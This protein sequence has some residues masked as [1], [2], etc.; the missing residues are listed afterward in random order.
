MSG[1]LSGR[2][3][4]EEEVVRFRREAEAAASLDHP[5]IVGVYEVGEHD[6]QLYYAMRL[7]EGASLAKRIEDCRTHNPSWKAGA[8]GSESCHPQFA[9][10]LLIK[11]AR[12]VHYAHERGVLHRDL[13]PGN[14][15]IDA[16]NEPYVT[17]FGLARILKSD[18]SL[19]LTGTPLGTL[20]YMAPEQA[21]GSPSQT[22]TAAFGTDV[23]GL[24]PLACL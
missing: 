7:V 13:K 16:N 2:W 10:R 15:L 23:V 22:T 18:S 12:A 4:S 6:G 14:I 24:Q 8:D 17:D 20:H 1:R 21:E 3:A 5:N 11:V 19:T 9:A